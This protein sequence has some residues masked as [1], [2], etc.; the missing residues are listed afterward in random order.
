MVAA[1]RGFDVDYLRV[2]AMVITMTIISIIVIR[3]SSGNSSNNI[4]IAII[5]IN[6]IG[7]PEEPLGILEGP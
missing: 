4:I 5:V 3:N 1:N 6:T 2:M 7:I